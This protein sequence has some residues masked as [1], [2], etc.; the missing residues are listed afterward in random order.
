MQGGIP[1]ERLVFDD[2]NDKP[3]EFYITY[4][5]EGLISLFQWEELINAAYIDIIPPAI[6]KISREECYRQREACK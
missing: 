2:P 5:P 1:M 6:T 3:S 4:I